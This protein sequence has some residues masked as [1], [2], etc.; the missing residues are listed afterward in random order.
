[1]ESRTLKVP[2]PLPLRAQ[3]RSEFSPKTPD[4]LSVLLIPHEAPHQAVDSVTTEDHVTSFNCAVCKA[5]LHP[6]WKLPGILDDRFG[7]VK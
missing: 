6:V 2:G 5:D 4:A 7:M 1:M 3:Y